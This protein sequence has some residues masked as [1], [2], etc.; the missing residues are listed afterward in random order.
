MNLLRK[1]SAA[2]SASIAYQLFK[3]TTNVYRLRVDNGV[4]GFQI[5]DA[6]TF[7]AITTNAWYFVFAYYD[8]STS[9]I[10]ISIN[11]GT[12]NEATLTG[13][14]LSDAGLFTLGA[15]WNGAAHDSH[16]DGQID[17]LAFGKGTDLD[18]TAIRTALYNGGAGVSASSLSPSNRTAFGVTSFWELDEASGTR[19]DSVGGND[20]SSITTATA[21]NGLVEGPADDFDPVLSWTD[22]VN[23]IRFDA[24]TVGNRPAYRSSGYLDFD[25]LD[26]SLSRPGALVGNRNAFTMIARLRLDTLPTTNPAVIFTEADSAGNVANRLAVTPGGSVVASYRPVGAT[27]ASASSSSPLAVST[28]AIVAVRRNGTSLQIFMNGLPAGPAVTIGAGIDLSGATTRI[29]GPIESTGFALL[30]GRVY[31]V[32]AVGRAL[33]D[34]QIAALS[35]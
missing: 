26:D 3:Q 5:V 28:D 11:G 6:T 23:S 21:A 2:S 17:Q 35:A 32:F 18:L 29:G 16:H 31:D 1:Y 4:G 33:S 30:D 7:G 22:R 9:K 19:R 8:K 20:L 25:G 27:I 10:G 13:T 15:A 34:A 12:P 24:A 14:P